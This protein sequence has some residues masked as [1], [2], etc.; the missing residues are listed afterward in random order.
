MTITSN[1]SANSSKTKKQFPYCNKIKDKDRGY[2]K[3][4]TE[5]Q[6]DHL[7]EVAYTTGT[8]KNRKRNALLLFMLYRHGLRISEAAGLRWSQINEPDRQLTVYRLKN[9]KMSIHPID[10]REMR[11]INA[12]KKEC[13]CDTY[14]F[15]NLRGDKNNGSELHR[16][17]S[18][19]GKRSKIGHHIH[20]HMFRHACGF[21]LANK[22][23]DTR[24][25]QEY[26]GHKDIT[27][28]VIY[29]EMAPNRFKG[30]WND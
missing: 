15:A 28:T 5:K 14:I 24:A 22:G 20:P 29:T 8:K 10:Y 13:H 19:L 27:K 3:Y 17:I 21:Y 12:W 1:H 11:M 6:I 4:L 18:N 9:G 16:T 26:L 23:V 30:F 7:I 2:P 25:I